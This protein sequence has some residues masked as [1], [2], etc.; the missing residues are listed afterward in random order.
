MEPIEQ[1]REKISGFPGYETGLER[2][3]SD[4]YVRSYLGEA[5]TDMAARIR[6]APEI[7][8]S[9]DAIVLRV[10]FADP[11]AFAAHDNV[12]GSD[13]GAVIA[14]DA[15]TIALADRAGAVDAES[16]AGYVGEVTAALNRR[17]DLM[18]AAALKMA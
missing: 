17:D 10:A 1:L 18:R 14:A 8:S 4:Q 12:G 6:L 9:I 11:K 15:D 3:R 5:L 7:Q 2:R 13:D 16:A